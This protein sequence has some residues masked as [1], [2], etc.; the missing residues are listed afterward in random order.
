[1]ARTF[2]SNSMIYGALTRVAMKQNVYVVANQ[3][4]QTTTAA[5]ATTYTGLTLGLLATATVKLAILEFGWA[6]SVVGG[7]D[8]SVGIMTGAIHS[9]QAAALTP[10]NQYMGSANT[11]QAYADNDC[12]LGTPVLERVFGSVGT[13]AVTGYSVQPPNV[14]RLDGSLIVTPGYFVAAYTT[15]AISGL[16]FYFLWEE[17]PL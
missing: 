2:E 10:R 1:M 17:L 8:G 13:L 11:S 4:A 3:A 12:T 14:A 9:T 7:A 6:N 5:L 16:S 15:K